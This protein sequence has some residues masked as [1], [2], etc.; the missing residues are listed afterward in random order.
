MTEAAP[1]ER[2]PPTYDAADLASQIRALADRGDLFGSFFST[3]PED[4]SWCQ[5]DVLRLPADFPYIDST[6]SAAILAELGIEFWLL[7]SNTCDLNRELTVVPYAQL[8]PLFDVDAAAS[9]MP[10]L[11]S[12]QL[13]RR[14]YVPYWDPGTTKH[15]VADFTMPVTVDRVA[16]ARICA[17][18]VA[19]LSRLSWFLLHSCLVRF[20]ARDDG[21]FDP[22]PD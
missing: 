6:G 15:F 11:R 19:H 1:V 14:F 2:W 3:R 7:L 5:G 9:D 17:P 20:L 13:G 16:L 12:Y 8:V 21:R 22:G 10:A 4:G 18:P